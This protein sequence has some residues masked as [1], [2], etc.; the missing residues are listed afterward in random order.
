MTASEEILSIHKTKSLNTNVSSKTLL[1]TKSQ[2][3]FSEPVFEFLKQNPA[4]VN[5]LVSQLLENH[6]PTSMHESILDA[7]SM[8]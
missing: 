3:G 5:R 4:E 6:F 8:P 2:G 7:V 1:S